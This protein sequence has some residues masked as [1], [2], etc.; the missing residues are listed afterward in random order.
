M[1][2]LNQILIILFFSCLIL[3]C[4]DQSALTMER[5]IYFYALENYNE[6]ANQFNKIILSY[7]SDIRILNT[8]NI[9][10]LAQAYQQ[11][12]LSQ[13]KL[14]SKTD[15]PTN[16]NLYY[17]S[18][19]E[20]IKKAEQLAIRPNKREEYRKTHLGILQNSNNY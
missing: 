14:A 17:E 9:E 18:A 10:L 19:L 16:K 11:L 4:K 1:K 12:S 5:G 6:A 2:K 20:N 15:N 8:K 7:G 3:T 13:A